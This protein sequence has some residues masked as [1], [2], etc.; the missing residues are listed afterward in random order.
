MYACRP[1]RESHDGVHC[2]API[3]VVIG[4]T[5]AAWHKMFPTLHLVTWQICCNRN[6]TTQEVNLHI[7]KNGRL[8][9]FKLRRLSD[10]EGVVFPGVACLCWGVCVCAPEGVRVGV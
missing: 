6:L 9:Y 2:I 8:V 4:H 7:N 1:E 5:V 3:H 10:K